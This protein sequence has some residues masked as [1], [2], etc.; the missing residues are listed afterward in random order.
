M[1]DFNIVE[2]PIV[3][4]DN[5][6]II[7]PNIVERVNKDLAAG[8]PFHYLFIGETGCGKTQLGTAIVIKS[9]MMWEMVST[10]K[11]YQE[12][13][14]YI[15]SDYT[16]KMDADRKNDTKFSINCLMIDDL[17]DEKPSTVAS[18]DYIGGLL[19]RRY[20]Y[21]KRNPNSR[22]IMTT[23][24]HSNQLISTYGSRVYD[25]LCEHFTI[26]KFKDHSFRK[27]GLE[28]LEG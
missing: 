4:T 24:L 23:N 14:R 22:T 18:H 16:D 2:D 3:E 9:K 10:M 19:E 1:S 15:S 7:N 20:L 12:H 28:I 21:I 8:N 27:T 26:C 5:F 25:R 17:G 6:K 11:H 13:I